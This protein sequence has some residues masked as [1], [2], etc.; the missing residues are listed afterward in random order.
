MSVRSLEDVLQAAGNPVTLLRNSQTGPYVYPVV[1]PEFSNWRDEQRAWRESCI[2]F[3]QS[4]HMTDMYME[5]PDALKVLTMLGINSFNDF[6][7]NK[8]K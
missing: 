6:G 4:Y 2:F 5:G 1:P 7:P 3:N 8:A